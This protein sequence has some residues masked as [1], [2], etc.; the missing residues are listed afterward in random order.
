MQVNGYT[1]D[2]RDIE[3]A[4]RE[5]GSRMTHLQDL[6]TVEAEEMEDVVSRKDT[7]VCPSCQCWGGHHQFDIDIE[8]IP[9]RPTRYCAQCH[10][11]VIAPA[12]VELDEHRTA[13]IRV[14]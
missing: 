5:Y 1:I 6:E 2:D 7:V 13:F 11:V 12:D 10:L 14:Q 3:G 4:Q 8:P 9:D